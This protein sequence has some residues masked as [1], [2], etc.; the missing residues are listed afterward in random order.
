MTASLL[1]KAGPLNTVEGLLRPNDESR[2][3]YKQRSIAAINI[4]TAA[5]YP[6][7]RYET[8]HQYQKRMRIQFEADQ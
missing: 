2:E 4:M 6:S 8:R 3:N 7:G 1:S 5:W